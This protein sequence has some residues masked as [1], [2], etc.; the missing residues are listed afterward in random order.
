MQTLETLYYSI[1]KIIQLSPTTVSS[2]TKDNIHINLCYYDMQDENIHCQIWNTQCDQIN[3]FVVTKPY[4]IFN[5]MEIVDI[6]V[7]NDF[8][9]TLKLSQESSTNLLR[10]ICQTMQLED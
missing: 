2:F 5:D 9:M 1:I 8:D 7:I 3:E 6:F 4:K 10:F